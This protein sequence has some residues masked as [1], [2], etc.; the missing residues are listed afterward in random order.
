MFFWTLIAVLALVVGAWCLF[1]A[2]RAQMRIQ[3]WHEK[4]KRSR[5]A[6]HFF[7]WFSSRNYELVLRCLGA[8][9]LLGFIVVVVKI[10]LDME[11][12]R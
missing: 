10:G 6:S 11:H 3:T 4:W 8:V 12:L 7:L 9:L 1:Y 2:E 5:R